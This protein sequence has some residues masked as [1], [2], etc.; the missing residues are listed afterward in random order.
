M[1][2]ATPLP[3]TS[4]TN[5]KYH[6]DKPADDLADAGIGGAAVAPTYHGCLN[7]CTVAPRIMPTQAVG[8]GIS[9]RSGKPRRSPH[10]AHRV[11]VEWKDLPPDAKYSRVHLDRLIEHDGFLRPTRLSANRLWWRLD[12]VE[13]W[14]ESRPRDQHRRPRLEREAQSREARQRAAEQS[15]GD[16]SAA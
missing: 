13:A 10:S 5:R 4:R 1:E 11:V 12:E 16:G 7:D 3:N 14:L 15:G 2:A 6:L 9:T 8:R